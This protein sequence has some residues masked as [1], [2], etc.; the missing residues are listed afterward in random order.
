MQ[1]GFVVATGAMIALS[2]LNPDM[3][4][5][6]E[7]VVMVILGLGLGVAMPILN[8]AIQNE[9]E[10]RDLGV[11]TSSSQLFRSLGSTIGT[12]V[13]GAML[14]A[15]I[16]LQ[17]SA[18]RDTPYVQSLAKNPQV[19]Q[20][21]SL[22]DTSTLLTLNMPDLKAKISDAAHQQFDKLPAPVVDK[23]RAQFDANQQEFSSK[24]THA[25]SDSLQKIFIVS[26]S[27]I[28]LSAVMVFTLK[29]KKLR[30]ASPDA[31]PGEE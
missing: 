17:A 15:G 6:Y 23:A 8:L 4:Y 29:E 26:S 20:I 18:I 10:Q 3:S 11:A 27:L 31:T 21:G 16:V 22:D 2:F 14:T 12:A 7:G 1:V 13:F 19:S 9:V 28:G 5:A 24:V 25:F 30:S